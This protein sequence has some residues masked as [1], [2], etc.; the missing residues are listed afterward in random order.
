MEIFVAV[1]YCCFVIAVVVVI[2][3]DKAEIQDMVNQVGK[4]NYELKM[5]VAVFVFCCCWSI[6]SKLTLWMEYIF[7]CCCC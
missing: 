3:V 7:C 2:S 5:F 6:T 1:V 4:Q